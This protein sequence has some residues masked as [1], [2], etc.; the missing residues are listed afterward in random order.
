[1]LAVKFAFEIAVLAVIDFVIEFMDIIAIKEMVVELLGLM[2][3]IFIAI[4]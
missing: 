2:V 3:Y 4:G 1:V